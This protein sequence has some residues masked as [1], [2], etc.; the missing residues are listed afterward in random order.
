MNQCLHW[1]L[2]PWVITG[3]EERSLTENLYLV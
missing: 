3:S 2:K 1:V